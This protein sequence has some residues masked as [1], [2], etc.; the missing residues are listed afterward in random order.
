MEGNAGLTL[1]TKIP[2]ESIMRNELN[3]R[4]AIVNH[5]KQNSPIKTRIDNRWVRVDSSE[6]ED[7]LRK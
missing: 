5:F 1:L 7:Y 6:P 3:L 4:D 2:D